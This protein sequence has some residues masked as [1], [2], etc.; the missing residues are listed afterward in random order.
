[1]RPKQEIALLVN[2]VPLLAPFATA[3]E[4]D[5]E[6]HAPGLE[7]FI[8]LPELLFAGTPFAIDRIILVRLIAVAILLL[9]FWLGLR[10]AR[11]VP[12]RGQSVAEL[13]LDFVRVQ[14]VDQI[15]GE[16]VGRRF[17]PLLTAMFFG[18][19]AM[20]ITGIVPG[21]NIAGTS[22]VAMPL[23]LALVAYAVFIYAG[24]KDVG[25]GKFLKNALFPS[26]VPWPVYII[27][28][29]V[30][31]I[32]IFIVR[33]FSLALRLLLNMVVGHLLLV[34]CFAATHFF[35]F[36]AGG[37]F[38]LFGVGTLLGGFVFTLIELLVAALQA[39]VFTLLTSVYI[40]QAVAEEH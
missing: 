19:F 16:K 5:G 28:A 22:L 24:I 11:R 2:A 3:A 31:F 34:L 36:T 21:L 15:L 27:L 32:N 26:G 14:I 13:A 17:L 37:W 1:V 23:V 38:S 4:G 40:Q 29:P 12:T 25:G 8:G 18:I 39:Y 20:N 35:F 30:E 7:E 33:P 6:F 9:L 10:K